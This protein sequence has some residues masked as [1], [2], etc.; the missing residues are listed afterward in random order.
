MQYLPK[1]IES[2]LG[3]AGNWLGKILLMNDDPDVDLEWYEDIDDR[4]CVF[5]DG[6]N[7]GQAFRFN[8][9]IGLS[10]K[11]SLHPAEWVA[12]CG[13]DDIWM[14][15]KLNICLSRKNR[16]D[17]VY[18]DAIM[19]L[20]NGEEYLKSL[21]FD[22]DRLKVHNYIVASSVMVK[23]ELAQ[24]VK[25]D[26]TLH[27]GEDWLF[28][29]LL[30]LDNAKFEYIPVPTVYYRDYSSNIEVRHSKNWDN[31]RLKLMN[32]INSLYEKQTAKAEV[33]L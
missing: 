28:Y 9:A 3:Q 5:Q 19:L 24:E 27:Y 16:P 31:N 26:D 12:F 6:Y 22:I 14:P 33:E 21:P 20:D 32:K 2:I 23:T 25:F 15:W 1:T 18:T 11:N 8:E 13:S 4:V 17:V 10:G 7:I 29:H 30:Y